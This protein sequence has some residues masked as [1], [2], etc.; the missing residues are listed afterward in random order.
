MPGDVNVTVLTKLGKELGV[1]FFTDIDEMRVMVQN[2]VKDP[3][4]QSFFFDMWAHEA[5][6][7]ATGNT[8]TQVLGPLNVSDQGKQNIFCVIFSLPRQKFDNNRV[9]L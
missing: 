6:C 1:T 4:L 8:I 3:I 9:F 5:R 7:L 2:L